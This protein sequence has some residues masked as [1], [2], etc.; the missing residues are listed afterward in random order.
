MSEILYTLWPGVSTLFIAISGVLVAIGWRQI[1]QKKR[2]AHQK[3]MFWAAITAILFFIFYIS[4]TLFVGSTT[5]GGPEE[6]KPYYL[7]FLFFHIFMATIGAVFG[8]TTLTLGYKAKFAKHRKWGRITAIIWFISASTGILVYLLL[9]I[10]FPGGH[11]DS[12]F[13]SLFNQ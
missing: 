8:I 13:N 2:E 12:L 11:T 10:M 3:T 9:Y 5:W 1:I 7:I 6:L 4:R